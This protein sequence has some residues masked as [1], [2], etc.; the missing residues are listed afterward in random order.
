MDQVHHSILQVAQ[1]ADS[2][3]ALATSSTL[4][5]DSLSA[6]A[7][8]AAANAQSVATAAEQ[9]Q[10]SITAISEQIDRSSAT[11]AAA[12]RKAEQASQTVDQLDGAVGKIG[13]V[14]ALINAIAEQ[15][16]LLAL[17]ATI[18]PPV[19]GRPDAASASWRTK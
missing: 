3:R 12:A 15:T 14:I 5:S 8:V 19:P 18:D 1:L 2:L 16:N 6:S 9:L 17:N 13:Q 11:A 7:H 4:E 10:A